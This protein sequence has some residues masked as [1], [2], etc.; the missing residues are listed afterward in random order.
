MNAEIKKYIISLLEKKQRL[1]EGINVGAYRY[2]DVG[3]I[4][5][6]SIMNFILKLEEHFNIEI[7]DD[8]MLS[9]LF[10][11]IDGLVEIVLRKI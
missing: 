10:Q 2:I 11:T 6:L 7:S 8:E 4:D 3:H 1:P 9:E 5:S